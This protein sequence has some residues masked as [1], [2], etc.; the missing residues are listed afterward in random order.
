MKTETAETAMA[1]LRER[2]KS[3]VRQR[4]VTGVAVRGS[5]GVSYYPRSR[6]WAYWIRSVRVTKRDA[7]WLLGVEVTGS[8]MN[9]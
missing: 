5:V 2:A 1:R 9:D 7:Q 8:V 6:T 3:N 4:V